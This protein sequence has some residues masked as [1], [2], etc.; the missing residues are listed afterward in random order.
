MKELTDIELELQ[1]KA[2][3]TE[4]AHRAKEKEAARQ[5]DLDAQ[6]ELIAQHADTLLLFAEHSFSNCTDEDRRY[7]RGCPRCEIIQAKFHGHFLDYELKLILEP[8]Y[9]D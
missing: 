1:I 3:K 5:A 4:A 2:L 6:G 9:E 7:D 8:R